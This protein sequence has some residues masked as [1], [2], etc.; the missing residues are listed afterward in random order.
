MAEV[1]VVLVERSQVAYKR[2][3]THLAGT[4]L[5]TTSFGASGNVDTY[6]T[7]VL[8]D[9]IMHFKLHIHV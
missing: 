7:C 3:G 2:A 1:H 4:Q 8:P 9:A 5:H 6:I